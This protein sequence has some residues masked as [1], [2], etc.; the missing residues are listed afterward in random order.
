VAREGKGRGAVRFWDGCG[1][2]GFADGVGAPLRNTQG[3]RHAQV[4]CAAL[5]EV[6][7]GAAAA[8]AERVEGCATRRYRNETGTGPHRRS[9]SFGGFPVPG[10]AVSKARILLAVSRRCV[11]TSVMP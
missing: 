11:G 6:L 10:V 3:T 1:K 2:V 5:V 7:C 9:A 8:S 4:E